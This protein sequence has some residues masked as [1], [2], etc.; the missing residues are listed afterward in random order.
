MKKKSKEQLTKEALKEGLNEWLDNQFATFGKW[1]LAALA[2]LTLSG[3]I[4][5]LIHLNGFSRYIR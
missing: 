1:T 5:I 2:S 4:W 3:I